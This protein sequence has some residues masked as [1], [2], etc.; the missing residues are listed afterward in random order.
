MRVELN[1]GEYWITMDE[2]L[3]L[4]SSDY[5]KPI[6]KIVHLIPI[7]SSYHLRLQ[8]KM[9]KD[10]VNKV[11]IYVRN[12]GLGNGHHRVKIAYDAGWKGMI[13]TND[14]Q[15]SGWRGDLRQVII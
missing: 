3:K 1:D 7:G 8:E 6:G 9:V 15:N 13:A 5:D 14:G 10:M 2:I 11:P 4:D 12:R